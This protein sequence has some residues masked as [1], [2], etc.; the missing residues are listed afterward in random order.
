MTDKRD[1]RQSG[2]QAVYPETILRYRYQ[3]QILAEYRREICGR[4]ERVGRDFGHV[5]EVTGARLD[6]DRLVG[7]YFESFEIICQFHF[8]DVFQHNNNNNNINTMYYTICTLYRYLRRT[9]NRVFN[10]GTYYRR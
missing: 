3:A 9:Y 10:L 8:D 7:I 4:S 1:H 6:V 5:K 2:P